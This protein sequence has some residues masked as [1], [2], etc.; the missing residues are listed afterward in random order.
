VEVGRVVVITYGPDA[1]KFAIIV[2]IIDQ[3]RALIDGPTSGVARQPLAY[4]RLHLTSF[5]V[6]IPRGAGSGAI[7]KALEKAGFADKWKASPWAKKT[8]VRSK[9]AAMTDFDRFKLM[10]AKKQRR[11]IV[12]AA[13][14]KVKKSA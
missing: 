4:K 5:V 1:G 6:P 10:L 2:D 11:S 3:A 8:V 13:V 7:V 14:K 9:R 12:Y